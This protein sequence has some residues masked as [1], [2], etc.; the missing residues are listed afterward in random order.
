MKNSCNNLKKKLA[1]L[2]QA[3]V[4]LEQLMKDKISRKFSVQRII[5]VLSSSNMFRFILILFVFETLWIALTGLYPMA[6]DEDFHLGI[7]KLYAHHISPFWSS[8]PEAAN[9]FGAVFRDPSYLY[10]YLMSFPYRL[11]SLFSSDQTIQVIWLRL[12]NIG[13]FVWGLTIFRK[14]LAFTGASKA[15]INSTLLIFILIPVIP[16]LAAQ[17]NYDNLLFPMTGLVLWLTL[18]VCARLRA[19]KQIKIEEVLGLVSIA[20]LTSLV[21]YAFLPV[22]L[23]VAV[24][25]LIHFKRAFTNWSEFSKVFVNSWTSRNAFRSWLLIIGLFISVGLFSQRYIVNTYL[26]HTPIPGCSKVLNVEACSDYG[27]WIRDYSLNQVKSHGSTN[28]AVFSENWLYGMWLRLFF[29][30]DGPSTQYETRGALLFPAVISIVVSVTGTIFLVKYFKA[31]RRVYDHD[32]VWLFTLV[33]MV[34]VFVLWLD[35]FEAFRR[36]GQPVAINGR[37][38]LPVLLPMMLLV[39]L[40]F[41]QLL[42]TNIKLK[43]IFVSVTILCMFWGGG[44]MTYIIR[45]NDDGS[46][47]WPNIYTRSVNRAVKSVLHPVMPG[48]YDWGKFWR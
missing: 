11:I 26:Y 28:A 40:A 19:A 46:W 34:Y 3:R 15:L 8:Q 14:V 48:F 43:A 6:F 9:A 1:K 17:I 21:K 7:I 42:K 32:T 2:S 24:Y 36:T 12:I 37:Y 27:P 30:V 16:L 33:S 44:A 5:S 39:A 47:W 4:Y 38:L 22:L 20:L 35:Q 25:L 45:S 10:H 41:G 13:L 23:A 31:I 18:K 29:S